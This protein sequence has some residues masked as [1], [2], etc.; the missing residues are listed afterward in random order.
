M[1][2]P[3]ACAWQMR[4]LTANPEHFPRALQDLTVNPST[5]PNREPVAAGGT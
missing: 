1:V 3:S 4:T 2:A 5:A